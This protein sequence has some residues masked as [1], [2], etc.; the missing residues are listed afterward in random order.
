[1]QR[2]KQ[3]KFRQKRKLWYRILK[4]ILVIRYKRPKFIY[5]GQKPT[6]QSMIL[7]NHVGTEAPMSLEMYVDFPIRMWGTSQMNSG[8]IQLYKYQTRVYYHEKKH[9]NLHLAR[10]FCL[11]A[12]PLTNIFYKGLKLISTYPDYRFKITLKESFDTLKDN[13]NIVVFPEISDEGYLDELK[14]FHP[15][16]IACAAYA[17][18]NGIDVLIYVSYYRSKEGVYLFDQPILYS[19]LKNKFVTREAMIHYLVDCCNALGRR[20]LKDL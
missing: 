12:S 16:F 15:G 10:L 18:K 7:S 11:L 6:H 3:K 1:M 4:K 9:W 2:T 19:D 20:A 17:Y 8:L 13:Q 5:L 14:G